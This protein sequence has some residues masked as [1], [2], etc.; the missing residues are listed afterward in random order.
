MVPL[1]WRIVGRS[2][3]SVSRDA[4]D[5]LFQF[6]EGSLDGR[7]DRARAGGPWHWLRS[8]GRGLRRHGAA[9]VPR[10]RQDAP[11]AFKAARRASEAGGLL[12]GADQQRTL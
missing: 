2:L 1:R 3:F 4:G 8:A 7:R 6:R 11:R 5:D 10:R 12:I 9:R